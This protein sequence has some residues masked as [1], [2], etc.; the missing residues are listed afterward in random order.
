MVTVS[1]NIL[2]PNF[3]RIAV[4]DHYTSLIWAKRYYE[5]GAIDLQ[6]EA[7]TENLKIFKENNYITRED[8]NSIYRI[9]AIELDTSV[10]QENYL[11]IGAYDCKKILSQRITWNQINF[12]GTVENY[13]R[14]I[15]TDNIIDPDDD[16][17]KINNFALKPAH[18]FTEEIQAQTQFDELD[19]K[20]IE[21][22]MANEYGW[23]VTF[24]NGVLYFDLFKGVD[25]S[26]SQSE[27][28][29]VVFSP[30]YD[31][32]SSTKYNVDS[33]E[34]KNVA[35]VGGEGEGTEKKTRAIGN[36]SGLSRFEMYVSSNVSSNDDGDLV[37][38]YEALVADGKERLAE[39]ATTVQFEG[40]IDPTFYKYK[41]DY[42]LGDIITIKNEYG[43]Q[44]NARIVEVAETWDEE[45]YT[46]D[47]TFD[48]IDGEDE[49]IDGILTENEDLLM[50][51]NEEAIILE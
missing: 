10:E 37:D 45:G 43:I 13:I 6:V 31:N 32:L 36:A 7:T 25:H 39:Q 33:S 22:C 16:L 38:Y 24:E 48:N 20:I 26:T 12:D 47:L 50:T 9:E 21:L 17:R 30:A 1:L 51:E 4:V 19:T 29:H 49:I 5:I 44:I 42:D 8:D 46:I 34:Y 3:Q 40:E 35:L 2:N 14:K 28:N 15:I 18:G 41:T 23:K 11:I 27:N